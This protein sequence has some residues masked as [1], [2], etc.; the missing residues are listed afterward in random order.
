MASDCVCNAKIAG[1]CIDCTVEADLASSVDC[2]I[3]S[4]SQCEQADTLLLRLDDMQQL[5]RGQV[6]DA[7]V[8]PSS[9]VEAAT[10]DGHALYWLLMPPQRAHTL[11]LS[12]IPYLQIPHDNMARSYHSSTQIGLAHMTAC[13]GANCMSI[14]GCL[15]ATPLGTSISMGSLHKT[16]IQNTTN[17]M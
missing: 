16:N 17:P 2:S 15:Q 7:D 9:A 6:P 12:H 1:I 4:S 5:Q 14:G 10:A 3:W 8:A 11:A 13:S